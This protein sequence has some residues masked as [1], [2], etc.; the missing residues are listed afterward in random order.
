MKGKY[1]R[2]TKKILQYN[3]D[4]ENIVEECGKIIEETTTS[5]RVH[6]LSDGKR[7]LNIIYTIP[8]DCITPVPYRYMPSEAL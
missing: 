1:V 2:I 7:H 4:W 6:I 5:V 3:P 8:K